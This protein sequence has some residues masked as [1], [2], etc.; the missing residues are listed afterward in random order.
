[1]VGLLVVLALVF[2]G[3]IVKLLAKTPL[4]WAPG[5]AALAGAFAMFADMGGG[6]TCHDGALCGLDA[7]GRFVE[8]VAGTGLAIVGMI[9]LAIAAGVHREHVRRCEELA[10]ALPRAIVR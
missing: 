6:E 1:M 7:I 2:V 5:A 4:W 10:E 8:L 9:V 3:V